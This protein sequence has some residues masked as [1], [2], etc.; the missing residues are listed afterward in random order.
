MREWLVGI[1]TVT[2]FCLAAILLANRELRLGA[3]Q[4]MLGIITIL[5]Y[6]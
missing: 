6:A 4:F 3:A 5:V 2:F 1:Q